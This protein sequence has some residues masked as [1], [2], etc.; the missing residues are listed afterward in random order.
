MLRP[1]PIVGRI[2]DVST[3]S[4]IQKSPDALLKVFFSGPL[5][6]LP[7]QFVGHLGLRH[8]LRVL[9]EPM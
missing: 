1:R 9:L 3:P 5:R 2:L 8:Q 7:G 6:D 4:L